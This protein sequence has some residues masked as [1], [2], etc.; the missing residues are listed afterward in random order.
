MARV[1]SDISLGF[2]DIASTHTSST[3]EENQG[4]LQLSNGALAELQLMVSEIPHSILVQKVPSSAIIAFIAAISDTLDLRS[5]TEH[6]RRHVV[7]E[8]IPFVDLVSP[9]TREMDGNQRQRSASRN[10]QAIQTSESLN[11][12]VVGKMASIE[13]ALAIITLVC[14]LSHKGALQENVCHLSL[15]R[16]E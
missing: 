10:E 7:D 11:N 4:R 13:Y 3:T 8:L 6:R 5:S 15:R 9:R 1:S 12:I 16:I 2:T 14:Q